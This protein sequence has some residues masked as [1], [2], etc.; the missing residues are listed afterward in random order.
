MK[1]HRFTTNGME[2]H[3]RWATYERY[4]QQLNDI[5]ERYNRRNNP[6]VGI[7]AGLLTAVH[8]V[9]SEKDAE[10]ADEFMEQVIL[11]DSL[12]PDHPIS[13]LRAY[14]RKQT[15]MIPRPSNLPTKAGA[16]LIK[17]WNL[18]RKGEKVAKFT[19]PTTT[20]EPL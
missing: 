15:S 3:E 1:L 19:A 8:I 7:P 16:G 18:V 6:L 11:G 12:E 9:L 5:Q 10:E 4:E 14:V 2:D 17:A 13:Q 20:P